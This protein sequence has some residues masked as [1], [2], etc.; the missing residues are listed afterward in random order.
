MP[1]VSEIV[2]WLGRRM[3]LEL[4][5]EWDNVGLLLGDP[6][7]EVRSVMTCLTLT[8]DVVD[9]AI[10]RGVQL[11]VTHHPILF[12][13]AQKLTTDS[14]DGA[15]VWRL[16]GQGVAVFSP[17]TA[18]DSAAAGINQQLA[19]ALGLKSI[20][21][22]RP[23]EGGDDAAGRCDRPAEA[24]GSG[25]AV[26][27]SGGSVVGAG[28]WGELEVTVRLGEFLQRV[29][30]V[31]GV[32]H[33]RFV[34][35]PDRVVRRVAVACGAGG[36]FLEDAVACGCDVMLTGEASFHTC[37]AARHRNLALVLPGHYAS[38]R[39]AMERLAE[40]IGRAFPELTAWASER[41]CDPIQWL[42]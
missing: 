4:G 39:P 17:H 31:L 21:A 7:A 5:E 11:V 19:E 12:R 15:I 18:Y 29:R 2:E 26:E 9:E 3:P 41:E 8:L 36:S 10:E 34:G 37:L 35:E 27:G 32:R 16:A 33:L 22:L 6:A 25:T 40:R 20:D 14:V 42:C 30:D 24:A 38:E 13:P 23:I 28:R 1:R